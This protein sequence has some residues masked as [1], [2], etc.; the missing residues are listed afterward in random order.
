MQQKTRDHLATAERN[1]IVAGLVI[2]E[3]DV[4]QVSNEW[5]VVVAFYAAVHLVN[6]FLWE[7]QSFEPLN[8]EERSRLA[9]TIA[10]LR[11]DLPA[12]LG[13][14]LPRSL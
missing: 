1:R 4:Q 9:F 3:S 8:H 2:G 11:P 12:T 5:A 13:K 14:R 6:A 10:E 7:R